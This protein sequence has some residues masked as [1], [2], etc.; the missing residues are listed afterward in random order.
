MRSQPYG[1]LIS[2]LQTP[3][4]LIMFSLMYKITGADNGTGDNCL[5]SRNASGLY[6][7]TKVTPIQINQKLVPWS[8]NEPG[9]CVEGLAED[10]RRW[11]WHAVTGIPLN[12]EARGTSLLVINQLRLNEAILTGQVQISHPWW[13]FLNVHDRSSIHLRNC[14]SLSRYGST[15]HTALP[16]KHAYFISHCVFLKIS[17]STFMLLIK[18]IVFPFSRYRCP[19]NIH[20]IPNLNHN[21]HWLVKM[22]PIRNE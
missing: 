5:Q 3:S 21:Q 13:F 17:G 10:T 6:A 19:P 12:R 14:T 8:K 20:E 16:D 9:P 22:I 7:N 2:T 11:P 1:P 15:L 4:Q 18:A